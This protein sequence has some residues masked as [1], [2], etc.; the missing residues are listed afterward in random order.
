V[1]AAEVDAT[2]PV[3]SQGGGGHPYGYMDPKQWDTFIGWMRDN[4][5]IS[6]LPAASEV[7]S[8]GYLPGKIP[9]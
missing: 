1:T 5:L 6:S 3:L 2:L 7:L 4:E 8:N 9:D